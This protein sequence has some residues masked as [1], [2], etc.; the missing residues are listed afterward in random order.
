LPAETIEPGSGDAHYARCMSA[1]ALL[2]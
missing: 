2:P 1:L